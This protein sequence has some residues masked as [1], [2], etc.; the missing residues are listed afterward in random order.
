[1]IGNRI[2]SLRLRMIRMALELVSSA[3]C[4]D[5]FQKVFRHFSKELNC[6]MN[7]SVYEPTLPS[8]EG[9][10]NVLFYLSGLTCTEQNFIQKSGFQRY[11]SLHKLLVVG[12]D[13]SPRKFPRIQIVDCVVLL[14]N[15]DLLLNLLDR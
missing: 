6:S 11:A 15:Y 10:L 1:L 14:G 5:G 3:K 12:P 8:P 13:T 4:Y 2:P 9:K 7:F